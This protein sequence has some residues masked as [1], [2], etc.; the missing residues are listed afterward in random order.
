MRC[1]KCGFI[2]FDFNRVCPKCDRELSDEQKRLNLPSFRP[3]PPQLLSRLVGEGSDAEFDIGAEP[4]VTI[5]G[6][7]ADGEI[8]AGL[9]TSFVD[10]EESPF[11]YDGEEDHEVVSP[12]PEESVPSPSLTETQFEEFNLDL[13]DVSL[14]EPERSTKELTEDEIDLDLTI[15]DDFFIEHPGKDPF[16]IEEP[17]S[18][19]LSVKEEFL[20]IEEPFNLDDLSF[21]D[22]EL[23]GT[24]APEPAIKSFDISQPEERSSSVGKSLDNLLLDDNP[25]GLTREIDMKKFRKDPPKSS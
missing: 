10:L 15:D 21:E 19:D 17:S 24:K 20:E 22:L 3:D 4:D 25:E 1:A 7:A 6:G 14:E 9:E 5:V 13:E 23:E 8:D 16:I 2:S 11:S 18:K 12:E